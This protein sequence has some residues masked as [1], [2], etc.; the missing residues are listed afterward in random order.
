MCSSDLF[1]EIRLTEKLAETQPFERNRQNTQ[2]T[3]RVLRSN[4]SLI[5]INENAAWEFIR[6]LLHCAFC[7]NFVV[8]VYSVAFIP[9]H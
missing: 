6:S 2:T 1:K 9:Y 3:R 7:Y 8:I 4:S 5:E